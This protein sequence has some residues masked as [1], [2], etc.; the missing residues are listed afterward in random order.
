MNDKVLE[1]RLRRVA[2]R[3]GYRLEKSRR[4]DPGAVDFGGY[5]LLDGK[6]NGVVLGGSQDAH[7]YSASLA[8]VE[9]FFQH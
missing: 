4:R 1:N 7:P 3:R 6:T 5:M 2:I 9:K 8:D